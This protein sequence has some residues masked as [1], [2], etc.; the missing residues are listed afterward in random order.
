MCFNRKYK[1]TDLYY[2]YL[3]LVNSQMSNDHEHDGSSSVG[4]WSKAE[5]E[6]FLEGTFRVI[7][8]SKSMEGTGKKLPSLLALEVEHKSD[9]TLRSTSIDSTNNVVVNLNLKM[10][11]TLKNLAPPPKLA[12]M[13]MRKPT[14]ISLISSQEC[15]FMII[16]FKIFE[17]DKFSLFLV[18]SNFL[19]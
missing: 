11:S 10:D 13:L 9:H 15:K 19:G 7:Q 6:L 3:K 1:F 2:K 4:R 14:Q 5:H 12:P 18:V 17:R 8:G 16:Q